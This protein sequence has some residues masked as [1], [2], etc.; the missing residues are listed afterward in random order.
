MRAKN[1]ANTNVMYWKGL[2]FGL[3]KGPWLQNLRGVPFGDCYLSESS[4]VLWMFT[5]LPGS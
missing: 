5:R 4:G 2:V 3:K 1:V